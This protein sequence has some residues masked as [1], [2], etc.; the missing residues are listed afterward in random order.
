MN[1]DHGNQQLTRRAI[2]GGSVQYVYQCLTCG[3]SM[4]QPISHERIR[5]EFSGVEIRDF[6]ESIEG[7][8]D[9][10][11]LAQYKAEKSAQ[12][13]QWQLDYAEYLRSPE[14]AAKRRQVLA[15]C[16]HVCEGCGTAKA[17]EVHHL[18]YEHVRDEFLFELVGVCKA[19][20]D[21]IHPERDEQPAS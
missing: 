8:Y 7:A 1:C 12:D 9:A 14:W 3:R 4:N 15:R 2:R 18:T 21:R 20:H 11:V 16:K 5:M 19:C 6:D 17:T 10:K 13:A